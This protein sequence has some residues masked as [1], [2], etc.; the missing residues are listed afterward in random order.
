MEHPITKEKLLGLLKLYKIS[1]I[2]HEH[3]AL[4][5]VRESEIKR[6]DIAGLHTKNLF[7]KNKKNEYFLFSSFENQKI[8]LKK[9]SKILKLGNIS[10]A[11]EERLNEIM[12]VKAGSVTPFGLLNDKNKCVKFFLDSKIYKSNTV[13]FHPLVNTSTITVKVNDLINFFTK[14]NIKV[15]IFDF[16]NNTLIKQ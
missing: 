7:F 4:H 2:L 5:T 10:F 6:G 1:F 11:K 16:K 3:S 14:N 13:N 12:S 15:N 8:D 9:I